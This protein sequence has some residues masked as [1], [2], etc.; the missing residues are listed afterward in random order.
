MFN[1]VIMGGN[2]TR[3]IDLRY[4]QGGMAIG[5]T[6]IA[7]S[8]KYTANGEKKEDVCFVDITFFGRTAE[9]ANQYLKKGSK[10]LIDG[11]LDFQQWVAQDGS[12]HSKHVVVVETLQMLDAKPAAGAPE[13]QPAQQYQQ[14]APQAQQY[15][16]P[17]PQ[18]QPAQ[19]QQPAPQQYQPPVI[20]IDEDE[21]PF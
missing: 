21:I 19:Y 17:V 11:R 4:S 2:I 5:N 12:K 8:R 14:P 15:Q 3:D 9:I 1:K 7:T 10:I 18:G 20:D 16:Q 6:A 13:G